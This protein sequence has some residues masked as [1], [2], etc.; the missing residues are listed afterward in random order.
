MRT[1]IN[2]AIFEVATATAAAWTAEDPTL[3]QG[4][5]G[6]ETDTN[7]MKMGDGSTAWTAL[8]Y[9]CETGLVE[10]VATKATLS[11]Y[12]T[13]WVANSDW[14]NAELTVT[15]SL[16]AALPDLIVKFF[17][18][19]IGSDTDSFEILFAQ[20]DRTTG[21]DNVTGLTYYNIDTDSL[22]IQTGSTG[23]SYSTE[24]SGNN[25]ALT[26]QA[27]YYKAVVYKLS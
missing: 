27:W 3:N 14:T 2:Q 8:E 21:G 15:H 22:K 11:R 17:V 13:G 4:E 24:G 23:I 5:W 6:L 7:K 10:Q 26:A 12:S 20:R 9:A 18:S 19:E 25:G 16:T 1:L